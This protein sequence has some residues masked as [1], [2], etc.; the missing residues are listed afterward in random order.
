MTTP[1][2]LVTGASGH[3]GRLVVEAL[4]DRGAAPEHIVATA[5]DVD[6]IKGL[7]DR[8][9]T[10]RRADYADPASLAA[11]FEGVDKALLVSSNA[12]GGDRV[13]QH[14]AV[15]EAAKAAGVGLLGYTSIP[16]ADTTT[17]IL[18]Q[19]HLA[20]ERVLAASGVPTV[21]LRN[22]WYHEN[23][24]EN[25]APALEHGVVLGSAG[26]GR[27][28][29]AA[30]RD[31]AEAAA[32]VLLAEDDQAGKVYELGGDEAF[33]LAEFARLLGEAAGKPIAYRDLPEEEYAAVLAG[34]GVPAPFAAVLA[35]SSAG[36]GRGELE[37]TTGDLGRLIGR[38]TTPLADAVRGAVFAVSG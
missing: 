14:T 35:D 4:L 12:V 34:A 38:P 16:F 11:A 32:A 27:V 9:V 3:L 2:I 33:T 29:A 1:T 23:Y 24:T 8:G 22:G 20:T 5:R 31:Y 25:A 6:A 37:V 13:G 30:R 18:A 17:M 15:I 10:V 21:L 7:A 19:D 26:D 36:V 28:S